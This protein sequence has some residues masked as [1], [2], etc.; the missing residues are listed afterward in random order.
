[1]STLEVA[2]PN[3][4]GSIVSAKTPPSSSKRRAKLQ[5]DLEA[6][7]RLADG[8]GAEEAFASGAYLGA[9]PPS[10]DGSEFVRLSSGEADAVEL[11]HSSGG[12]ASA[13]VE[14]PLHDSQ[15]GDLFSRT[16]SCVYDK[17]MP[18]RA[19]FHL[20]PALPMILS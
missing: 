10:S 11:A 7:A 16:S 4:P 1:M 17:V 3:S 5:S 14:R 9:S 15:G 18:G 12:N 2:I 20:A 6:G 8:Q 13:P 19:L